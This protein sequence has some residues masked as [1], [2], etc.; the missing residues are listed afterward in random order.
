[1][2]RYFTLDSFDFSQKV[3]GVRV[4]I[5]SPIIE[6]KVVDNKRIEEV[7]KT[8]RELMQ[9]R[10]KVV[11]LAHQGREGSSDFV[12]LKSHLLYLEKHTGAKISF[13]KDLYS[14][15]VEKE[16]SSMKNS[17][18][19]LL[20]NLRFF[21]DEK[22]TK[23]KDNKLKKLERLFDFYV[24]EAF[25]VSHRSQMSVVGFENIP[26]IAGRLLE[27]EL[28][29]LHEIEDAKAPHLFL[30]GGAK[31]DDL[32]VLIESAV[33][34]KSI[35][36]ILLSGV[37]G[38]LGL[39]AKGYTIGKKLEFMKENGY[40]SCLKKLKKLMIENPGLF[41]IPRDVALLKDGKR[42][43]IL[44]SD[45]EKNKELLGS[46]MLE[47]IGTKTA[48]DY[49]NMLKGAGSIYFKGPP[50]NFEKKGMEVGTKLILEKIANS[51]AFTFMGGGHSVTAAEMF[52]RLNS[53][54]YVSLAGGALVTFLSGE[55]LPGL[56]S[57]E[58]SFKKFKGKYED[59]IVIGSNTIDTGVAVPENF[60][61]LELGE[62]VKIEENFK[63]S[64]GG[65]GFNVSVCLSRLGAKVGYLGKVAYEN[66]DF[67][68]EELEKNRITLIESDL[69]RR[70]AAKSI[71]L[72]FKDKDRIILTY[73]GQNSH[74]LEK[75]VNIEEIVAPNYYFSSL[76]GNSFETLVKF[77]EKIKKKNPT[78]LICYNP[79]S[80]LIKVEK[81]ISRLI[82][83]VDVLILN[84]EEAQDLSKKE[85]I[86]E[87]LKTLH[88][89]GPKVV[90]ITDGS[91]GVYAYDGKNE[92][93][94]KAIKTQ[95]L[96]STGAGDSFA[97]TF[98]FFYSK[99]SSIRKALRFAAKNAASVVSKKGS[100]DGLKYYEDLLL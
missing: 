59:F 82:K 39:L 60:A 37:I 38:E 31:P 4:D 40:D 16:I 95:V 24:F 73:R 9:K 62:K 58:K 91:R 80:Y 66:H 56:M 49:G 7:S 85:K 92:Y 26:V 96:D 63:V 48:Q 89:V 1:M 69:S 45:L 34:S 29:G 79:S 44:T 8:I 74:L 27:R 11:I 94:E 77:A 88:D 78:S 33:K 100:T 99:S 61:S 43:E 47:D 36:H 83:N 75:D 18:V 76:T 68:K 17:E 6:G 51:E 42:V 97:G 86:S 30:F 14:K 71:L 64:V 93:F 87:C 84:Y 55:K 28:K 20:E 57:L 12:S 67:L 23:K 53:F 19:L 35:D 70:P 52:K 54:S 50:G 98:F 3:V 32:I 21:D 46:Y 90:I 15:D 13:S 2:F 81:S 72:D 65:G 41:E 10:A 5:N 22:D 25:S